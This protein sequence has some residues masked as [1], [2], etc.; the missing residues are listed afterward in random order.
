MS[1]RSVLVLLF[2]IGA[3]LLLYF[4]PGRKPPALTRYDQMIDSAYAVLPEKQADSLRLLEK[5]AQRLKGEEAEQ[6]WIE[7]ASRWERVGFEAVGAERSRL[8]AEMNPDDAERWGMAG[9]RFFELIPGATEDAERVDYVFRAI[10]C[11][12]KTLALNTVDFQRKIRLAD[13]YTEYQ[14]NI[15]Q[16]V[17]LLREVA[18]ADP[19]NS[20][21][22]LRLGRFALMS[23]Q[24]DK[25]IERFEAVLSRDSLNLPA[26][27]VLAQTLTNSGNIGA[28]KDVLRKGIELFPDSA[29]RTEIGGLLLQLEQLQ[30]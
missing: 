13:C 29:T 24:Q 4:L 12:E 8:A 6:A 2:S 3:I 22:Q 5:S 25:A 16:G 11:Y 1:K 30:R 10:Y 21:A 27:I 20:D 19:L 7:L 28:A 17:V 18:E 23:G 26:R 14:G 15:M 9:D